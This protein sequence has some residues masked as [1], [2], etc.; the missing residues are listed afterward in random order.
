MRISKVSIKNFRNFSDVM[1]A[2]GQK[3]LLVGA[4]ASGKSNFI[5]ALRLV[6]DPSLSRR[7]R[8][9]TVDDFWH[10]VQPWK[11]QE[12]KISVELTD[13]SEDHNLRSLLDT[14]NPGQTGIARLTYVYKPKGNIAPDN[15]EEKD[16]DFRLYG[17]DRETNEIVP[18]FYQHLNLRVIEALRNA[19]ADLIARRMPLK[20][21]MDLYG[22]DGA[23]LQG[24]VTYIQQAN[25]VIK[26]VQQVR[27]TPSFRPQIGQNK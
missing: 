10:G 2:T 26:Q 15:A 13:F 11:G 7:E 4:N 21:L 3:I 8:L 18:S 24:V 25:D 16:Y 12:I 6:L 5:H 1:V 20:S 23:A 22:I 19:E 17:G 14:Y 27:L 9:L